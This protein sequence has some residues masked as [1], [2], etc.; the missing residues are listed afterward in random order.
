MAWRTTRS[1]IGCPHGQPSLTCRLGRP[2]QVEGP[3]CYGGRAWQDLS[4]GAEHE[5]SGLR[6]AAAPVDT[7]LF[8]G[9]LADAVDGVAHPG[10]EQ[11]KKRCRGALELSHC[12]LQPVARDGRAL[13]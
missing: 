2:I 13:R 7:G 9:G 5:I 11:L 8:F 3:E 10:R 4:R 1:A 6:P 12:V